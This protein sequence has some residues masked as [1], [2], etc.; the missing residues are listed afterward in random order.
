MYVYNKSVIYIG[1]DHRGFALKEEIKK[2]LEEESIEF[3]DLGNVEYDPDD[4]YPD[5]AFAV[6]HQVAETDGDHLG[7]IICRNG[8]GV[9][10]AANKVTGV[11]AGTPMTVDQ[12]RGARMDD[13]MNVICIAA[14]MTPRDILFELT[15]TFLTTD[16]SGEERHQRRLDKIAAHEETIA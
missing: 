12:V 10:I 14:D 3:R 2:Y 7:I 1:A 4:D 13:D 15:D 11:R 6:A 8:I 5:F 16:F 9:C